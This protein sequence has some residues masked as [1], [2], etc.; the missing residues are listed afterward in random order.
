MSSS[1][2]SAMARS[3]S[4]V[5]PLARTS[6]MPHSKSDARSDVAMRNAYPIPVVPGSIPR[7]TDRLGVL[8]D[9]FGHVEVRVDLDDVVQILERL[10]EAQELLSL[11]ALNADRGRRAHREL[12][13]GHLDAGRLERLPHALERRGGGVDGDQTRLGFDILG[14]GVDRRELDRVDV[15]PFRVDLDDA[16]L[17]EE[18]LHRARFAELSTASGEGGTD[19]GHGPVAVVGR[20]LDHHRNPARGI[21]LVDDALEC[22]RV[23]AADGSVDRAPDV[24]ARHVDVARAVDGE[25]KTEIPVRVAAAFLRGD[26]DLLGHLG[27]DHAA[28]DVRGPLLAL[29]LTPL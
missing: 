8:E 28:L 7:I 16:F 25:P 1:S 22:R 5:E 6:T 15:L 2:A 17:L 14:A 9:L 18:P 24:L 4:P 29:D 27:E 12:G 23:A 11:L 13:G 10:D 21:A 20:C 26:H 3:R 19:L